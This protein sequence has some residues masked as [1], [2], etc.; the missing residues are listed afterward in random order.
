MFGM[1][2]IRCVAAISLLALGCKTIGP[3]L[4]A[5]WL[6]PIVAYFLLTGRHAFDVQ[7]ISELPEAWRHAPAAPSE[8]GRPA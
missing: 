8:D 4:T 6:H 1:K 2:L 7:A 5:W 3:R